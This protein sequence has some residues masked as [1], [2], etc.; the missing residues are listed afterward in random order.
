MLTSPTLPRQKSIKQLDEA[1]QAATAERSLCRTLRYLALALPHVSVLLF[2][3]APVPNLPS[4]HGSRATASL[5][6]FLR[7]ELAAG[8]FS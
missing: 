8:S 5:K 4:S 1:I 6:C 7:V 3:R 2:Y